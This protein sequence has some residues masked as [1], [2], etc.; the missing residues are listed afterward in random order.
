MILIFRVARTRAYPHDKAKTSE[1]LCRAGD[2]GLA[3]TD[4]FLGLLV[5][6][7][8]CIQTAAACKIGSDVRTA[9]AR[10]VRVVQSKDMPAEADPASAALAGVGMAISVVNGKVGESTNPLIYLNE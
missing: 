1:L 2:R 9:G 6:S 8:G 10:R 4:K 5:S 7:L 3:E